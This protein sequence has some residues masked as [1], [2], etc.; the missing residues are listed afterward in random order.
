MLLSAC[1]KEKLFEADYLASTVA[2]KSWICQQV[3]CVDK[4]SILIQHANKI[5]NGSGQLHLLNNNPQIK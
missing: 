3:R 1:E 2:C 4:L 5:Y